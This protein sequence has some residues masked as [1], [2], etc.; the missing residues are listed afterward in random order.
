MDD[1]VASVRRI[2]AMSQDERMSLCDE[3]YRRQPALLAHVLVLQ[4]L[5]VP[6]KKVDRVLNVLL[7]L[8][9]LFCR[10]STVNLPPVSEETLERVNANQL[11]LL[12]LMDGE[13]R[14]EAIRL[15]KLSVT[16]HPEINA[17]AFIIGDLRDAG[18]TD[19]SKKED[20]YCV[21]AERN[22]LDAIIQA[23]GRP[24]GDTGALRR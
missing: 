9:D 18:I 10:T 13:E 17:L 3:V 1:V 23:R 7:I 22:L 19:M 24:G 20:E 6:M 5:G 21:R 2:R 15:C 16:S 12:K 4:R 11:A 14:S 8:Y